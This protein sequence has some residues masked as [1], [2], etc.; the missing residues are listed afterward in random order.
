MLSNHKERLKVLKYI[1]IFFE[2]DPFSAPIP[3]SLN[4][5]QNIHSL[6]EIGPVTQEDR[7]FIIEQYN[8]LPHF[9]ILDDLSFLIV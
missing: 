9:V 2:I 7:D 8:S 5:L 1:A 4:A 6:V 3:K